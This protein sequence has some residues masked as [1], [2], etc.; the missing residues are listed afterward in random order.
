MPISATCR[1]REPWILAEAISM[2]KEMTRRAVMQ[3]M[4]EDRD[5]PEHRHERGAAAGFPG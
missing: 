4:R 2:S 1:A 5:Q 3:A